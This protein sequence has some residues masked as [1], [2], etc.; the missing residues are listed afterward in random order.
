MLT[1]AGPRA[2]AQRVADLRAMVCEHP[3]TEQFADEVAV[4]AAVL[5]RWRSTGPRLRCGGRSTVAPAVAAGWS[6]EHRP[7]PDRGETARTVELYG[8]DDGGWFRTAVMDWITLCDD[9]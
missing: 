1:G 4:G 7:T 2:L 8:P 6:C 5:R 9:L 3:L